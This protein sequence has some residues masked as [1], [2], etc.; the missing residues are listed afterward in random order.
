[1]GSGTD[2]FAQERCYRYH[3]PQPWEPQQVNEMWLS[4]PPPEFICRLAVLVMREGNPLVV[5]QLAPKL[6]EE[7]SLK[8]AV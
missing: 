8:E 4:P 1:M 6:T 7:P 5:P 3:K 2:G